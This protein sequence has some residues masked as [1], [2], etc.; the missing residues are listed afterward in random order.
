[1]QNWLFWVTL[2]MPLFSENQVKY[3]SSNSWLPQKQ[4][5]TKSLHNP[6][7]TEIPQK[8]LASLAVRCYSD[9]VCPSTATSLAGDTSVLTPPLAN[10]PLWKRTRMSE[11]VKYSWMYSWTSSQQLPM[12]VGP[13]PLSTTIFNDF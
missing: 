10:A 13:Y 3:S 1:M 12:G 8:E 4:G 5:F 6:W 9:F 2:C 7:F 11:N